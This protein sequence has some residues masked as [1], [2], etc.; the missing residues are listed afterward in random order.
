MARQYNIIL[1]PIKPDKTRYYDRRDGN[2]RQA[3]TI[4]YKIIQRHARIRQDSTRQGNLVQCKPR[5]DKPIQ[6]N[7]LQD[8][9]IRDNSR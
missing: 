7:I 8:K 3:N 1:Y 9:T 4:Q 2:I 6:Y 5:Q